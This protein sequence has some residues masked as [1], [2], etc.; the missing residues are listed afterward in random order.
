[1][2][3]HLDRAFSF[4][5]RGDVRGT[6]E[7]PFRFGTGIFTPEL[8]R[9][10]DSNL[11]YVDQ[12]V[13]SADEL[14]AEADRLFG[15]AGLA[16][17]TI[18][19]RDEAEGERLA[20]ELPHWDVDHHVIMAQLREPEAPVD[21]SGVAEVGHEGIRPARR[22]MITTYPWGTPAVADQLLD[23]KPLL[24]R[25][26]TVRGFGALADGAVVSYADL[27]VD[28]ADAQIEDVATLPEHRGRGYA[29]AV[30]T[31][32]ADEARAAGA[33]F[34]FLVADEH[35]WPKGLYGRLG[36]DVVG[37]YVKLLRRR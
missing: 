5:R 17:R 7:Q 2:T 10:F 25:W 36:F 37:R 14:V 19:F 33:D 1:M 24:A 23:Y 18:L 22:A 3:D 15:E 35:D 13:S 30:V 12:P 26:V 27:Y 8:P 28:G 34:V 6:R 21:T 16:H 29:K 20:A 32:A 31:R 4:L 9:R 11:L